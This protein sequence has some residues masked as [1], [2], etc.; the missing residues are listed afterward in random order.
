MARSTAT[1]RREGVWY[2]GTAMTT[3]TTVDI[4]SLIHTKPGLHQGRPCIEGTGM[5]IK[6][7]GVLY[8]M[9]MSAE[10]MQEQ[11]PDIDLAHFYG[12]IAFYLLNREFIQVWIDEDD[13]LGEE[14]SKKYPNG[15]PPRAPKA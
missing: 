14:Y 1:G 3:E 12:A 13:R 2:D 5:T 9:G 6:R 8:Q 11:Y 15:W 4:G 10:E 7:V